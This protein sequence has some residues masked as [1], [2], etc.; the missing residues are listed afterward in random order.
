MSVMK[1]LKSGII[2]DNPVFVQALALC[3]LMAVT[4]T[5]FSGLGMGFATTLVL[6][7]TNVSISL[8][9]KFIPNKVRIPSLIVIIAAIV[10]IVQL[11]VRAYFREVDVALGIFLPLI[12]VNCVVMG[13]GEAYALKNGPFKSAVDG[14]ASGLGFGIALVLLAAI[15]ELFGAGTLFYGLPFTITLPEAFPRIGIFQSPPGA[16]ISLGVLIA[17]LKRFG[18]KSTMTPKANC[19]AH[20]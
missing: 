16:F 8:L 19:S 2:S 4:S 17:L 7:A 13:R 14:F 15:R 12:A 11:F 9:R 3:P 6:M 18:T 5:T 1:T 10:T 20:I